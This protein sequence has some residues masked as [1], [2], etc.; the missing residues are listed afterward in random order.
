[1]RYRSFSERIAPQRADITEKDGHVHLRV[2]LVDPKPAELIRV[3]QHLLEEA[4]F[5][6]VRVIA[7]LQWLRTG[8]YNDRILAAADLPDDQT[9]EQVFSELYEALGLP[10]PVEDEEENPNGR[11]VDG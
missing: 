1:M 9:P 11:P 3:S 2:D 5:S 6:F 4:G 10:A 7:A 8:V